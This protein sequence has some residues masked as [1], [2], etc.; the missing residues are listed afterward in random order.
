MVDRTEQEQRFIGAVRA[1]EAGRAQDV[2][3]SDYWPREIADALRTLI[4]TAVCREREAC[5]SL[6]ESVGE[7]GAAFTRGDVFEPEKMRREI[8]LELAKA[9][10][11]RRKAATRE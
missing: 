4:D 7:P 2:K 3:L 5:A 11:A 9:I 10:R 1:F 6:A 8:C